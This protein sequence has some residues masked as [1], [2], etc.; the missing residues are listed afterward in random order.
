MEF[1]NKLKT[2]RSER[3]LSQPQLAELMVVSRSTISMWELGKRLPDVEMLDRLATYLG[4]DI[5][6]LLDSILDRS[7]DNLSIMVVE[8]IP[9][10]LK[11]NMAIIKSVMK[12]AN[13]IGF[14]SGTVARIFI[15]D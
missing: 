11:G 8:D 14:E 12:N 3:G 2:L 10:L 13:V 4:V 7:G 5:Q 6:V 1:A 15:P 9:T